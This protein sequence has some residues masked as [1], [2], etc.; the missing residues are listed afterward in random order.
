MK[1]AQPATIYLSDYQPSDYLIDETELYF[2]LRED[3]A[4]VSSTLQIRR[5]PAVEEAGPDLLL[6]GVDLELISVHIDGRQLAAT[7]YQLEAETLLIKAVPQQ[8]MLQCVSRSK[9]QLNKSM[10]GLYR[11]RSMFCT[12]CEA[13]GF[14]K[15]TWYLDR[16]D[17]LSR[18]T[19]HI[20]AD[21]QSFPVLLSN[22]NLIASEDV[23]EGRQR[24]SWVDPFR[25]PCY[26]FA[27]VAGDLCFQQDTFTSPDCK[28]VFTRRIGNACSAPWSIQRVGTWLPRVIPTLTPEELAR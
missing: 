16:P 24:V 4:E 6:Q 7:D 8:F 19:T 13:Q 17:V 27:L 20:E 25:K 1:E 12:Q 26:L 11:S 15:I 28:R 10:E 23:G 3:Y 2:D 9:P 18:F 14:R 22:G 5:N 21:S